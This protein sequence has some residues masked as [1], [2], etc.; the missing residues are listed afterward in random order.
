MI[1]RPAARL[2]A[3]CEAQRGRGFDVFGTVLQPL[4]EEAQQHPAHAG[5]SDAKQ[6]GDQR[7]EEGAGKARQ[8]G[9]REDCAQH[10]RDRPP[11]GGAL[12]DAADT[13]ELVE[14]RQLPGQPLAALDQRHQQCETE[15]DV[16]Q[17]AI[18]A[19]VVQQSRQRA[20][21]QP[22]E[23]RT[24]PVVGPAD[25]GQCVQQDRLA[26]GETGVVELPVQPRDQAPG[27][28][29]QKAAEGEGPG[30][31]AQHADAGRDGGSLALAD[32]RP[33]TARHRSALPFDQGHAEREPENGVAKVGRIAD[34]D[35]GPLDQGALAI[36]D[37][38]SEA[39][40]AVGKP[41][42]VDR[43][44]E[45]SRHH[46]G[47]QRQVKPT[48]AQRRQADD[49]AEDAGHHAAREQGQLERQ[50]EAVNQPQADPAADAAQRELR[51]RD[52]AELPVQQGHG[53]GHQGQA[54]HGGEGIQPVGRQQPGAEQG[55]QREGRQHRHH[56]AQRRAGWQIGFV[57]VA[58][59][60]LRLLWF[61][62]EVAVVARQADAQPLLPQNRQDRD[63]ECRRRAVARNRR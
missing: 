62:F 19:V 51:Q 48:H 55:R 7:D 14:I 6:H 39:G 38:A 9:G 49:E 53:A 54:G 28:A 20:H 36:D 50:A 32:Q 31:V 4:A 17:V 45:R 40:P 57:F 58:G 59:H 63:D 11:T 35:P 13:H 2:E 37:M 26:G 16:G 15:E 21:Q 60:G 12:D 43:H 47:Q 8:A 34:R 25:H 61:L 41:D 33:G 5:D 10:Q 29:G 23:D 24:H 18:D 27:Q 56:P 3:A 44:L 22:R 1:G 30:L 42:H 46:Q 52:H